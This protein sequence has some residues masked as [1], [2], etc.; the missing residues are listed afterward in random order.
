MKKVIN[1][2]SDLI[3]ELR[4]RTN[5]SFMECKKAL[6]Q[7]GGDLELAID[8][9]RKFGLEIA[10]RKS[11]RTT[12]SG[13]IATQVS[14]DRKNGIM[15][16][17]NCETDF[18]A[19]EDTFKEFVK[20]IV[21]TAVAEKINNI[22][23]LNAKFEIQR[24]GLI[25]KIGENV[26][27][28]R[29]VTLNGSCIGCYTHASKIGVMI[30]VNHSATVELIKNIAMHIIAKN[31]KFIHINDVPKD[32]IMREYRVQKDIAMN[33]NKS[34]NIL[35]KIIAGRMDK[36]FNNIVLT[37]QSY[38]LDINKKVGSVLDEHHIKVC[39]FIRFELGE[40][41]K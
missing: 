41:Y 23:I 30:S 27:I 26:N 31:P 14:A 12:F 25:A 11:N 28:R 37:Q 19:K 20:T 38:L 10:A 4:R 13:L 40:N 15:I 9:I 7:A 8:N 16:E 24:A 18:V 1:I 39:E 33:F 17:V 34:Q 3:K 35:E 36:F 6:I 21:I 5:V 32:V 22:N 29:F 2:G